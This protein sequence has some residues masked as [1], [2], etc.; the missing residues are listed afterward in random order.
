LRLI[1]SIYG[2]IA[3]GWLTRRKAVAEQDS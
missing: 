3:E 2:E 1:I